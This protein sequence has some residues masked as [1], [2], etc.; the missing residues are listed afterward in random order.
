MRVAGIDPGMA[1]LGIVLMDGKHLIDFDDFSTKPTGRTSNED[2][3]IRSQRMTDY[4]CE[5]LDRNAPIDAV[6]VEE[7]VT[8]S[9]ASYNAAWTTPMVIGFMVNELLTKGYTVTFRSPRKLPEHGV[10]GKAWRNLCQTH[11]GLEEIDQLPKT[12]R[13]HVMCAA[14]HACGVIEKGGRQSRRK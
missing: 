2:G 3:I 7:Y 9:G 11:K 5:F 14:F 13:E 1:S 8:R 4:V 6:V 12:R 10:R